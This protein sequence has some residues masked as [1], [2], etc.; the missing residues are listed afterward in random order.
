MNGWPAG[1]IPITRRAES[2][3]RPERVLGIGWGAVDGGC[4]P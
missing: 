3:R 2:A 4:L 1:V